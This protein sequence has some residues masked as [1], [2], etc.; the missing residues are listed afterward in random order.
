MWGINLCV[1]SREATLVDL[2]SYNVMHFWF[3]SVIFCVKKFFIENDTEYDFCILNNLQFKRD[4]AKSESKTIA[5]ITWYYS[6][7]IAFM[8]IFCFQGW[9]EC[10]G[11]ADRS[12][13]DLNQHSKA[14]GTKLVA[15]KKLQEPI[16]FKSE[17]I[18][19]YM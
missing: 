17:D 15:E 10:V 3:A 7:I 14:T 2:K 13:Y 16:S 5:K 6:L 8:C 11:C 4:R 9:V 12:C 1:K 18:I 19:Q